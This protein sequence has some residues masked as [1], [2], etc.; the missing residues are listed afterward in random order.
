MTIAIEEKEKVFDF[1]KKVILLPKN[2]TSPHSQ[3][4]VIVGENPEQWAPN[5]PL[6]SL[7]CRVVEAILVLLELHKRGD[8]APSLQCWVSSG[9]LEP[10]E[11]QGS[12]RAGPSLIQRLGGGHLH[13]SVLTAALSLL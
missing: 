7:N 3:V 11:G 1:Q 2:S 10:W 9:R 8:R 13:R 4:T 12:M 6:C 5:S